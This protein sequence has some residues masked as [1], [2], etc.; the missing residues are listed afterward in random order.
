MS[1]ED[2]KTKALKQMGELEDKMRWLASMATPVTAT[3]KQFNSTD[4]S[5][6][7]QKIR[8][9]RV[10]A[11]DAYGS[12][13]ARASTTLRSITSATE[14]VT[15]NLDGHKA[16]AL[17]LRRQNPGAIVAAVTVLAVAPAYRSGF[18]PLLRNA[19]VGGGAAAFFL[20]PE[21]IARVAPYVD[22]ASRDAT[23]QAHKTAERLGL[24]KSGEQ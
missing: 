19:V 13:E 14:S 20:Y 2:L 7:R 6:L 11:T 15:G 9:S 21:F 24:A 4:D 22:R 12:V 3:L 8:A 10:A 18:R 16:R 23:K 17:E 5:W 1:D